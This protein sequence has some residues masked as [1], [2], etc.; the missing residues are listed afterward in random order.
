MD[1]QTIDQEYAKL[2]TEF[3]DVAKSVQDL[4]T[5]M[6]AAGQAGDANATAWL[7]DLKT[8]AQDISDEQ[9][10]ANTLLQA[11]HAYVATAVE[12]KPPLYAPGHE[13]QEEQQQQQQPVQQG[14]MFGGMMGGGMM[15]GGMGHPFGGFLNGGFGQAMMMG[16]GIGLGQSL[17]GSLFRL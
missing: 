2:Q 5:K 16:G 8:V 12:E 15:G 3:Q 6:Q 11:I 13:P 17:I 4:A 1:A 10:Q 7:V 14:G 9:T